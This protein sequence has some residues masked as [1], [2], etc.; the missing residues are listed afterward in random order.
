MFSFTI[1]STLPTPR[2]QT[3]QTD[4]L[5]QELQNQNHVHK[6]SYVIESSA[7]KRN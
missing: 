6:S 4:N 1:I 5:F 7:V 2:Q 3:I